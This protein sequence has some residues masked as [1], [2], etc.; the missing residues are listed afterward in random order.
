MKY[1]TSW[2]LVSICAV[3]FL[4]RTQIRAPPHTHTEC[5]IVL[6]KLSELWNYSLEGEEGE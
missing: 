4:L 1:S 2:F 5:V 3:L 6:L